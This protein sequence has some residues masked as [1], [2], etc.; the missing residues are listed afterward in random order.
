MLIDRL[1]ERE[2][3]VEDI[4]KLCRRTINRAGRAIEDLV[5]GKAVELNFEEG[6]RIEELVKA[7]PVLLG[8]VGGSVRVALQ[9]MAEAMIV[10]E[11]IINNRIV[12]PEELE[13]SAVTGLADAI[14]ELKRYFLKELIKGNTKEAERILKLTEEAYRMLVEFNFPQSVV[15][16]LKRKKD[17]ARGVLTSML[18]IMAEKS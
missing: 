7:D 6:K 8:L 18:Q 9:E 1:K 12:L 5:E 16:E 13:H 14:G 11:A 10:R 4:F 3:K 17:V 2:R 15:P